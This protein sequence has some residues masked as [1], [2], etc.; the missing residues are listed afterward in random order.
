MTTRHD[1]QLV[2]E[3]EYLAEVD[4]VLVISADPWSPYL[5]DADARKLDEVRRALRRNDTHAAAQKARVYKLT[6]VNAA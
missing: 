4:V 3:G 1:V 6:P 2:H 5:V